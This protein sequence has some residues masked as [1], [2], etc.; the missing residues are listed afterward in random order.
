M[1]VFCQNSYHAFQIT[2]RYNLIMDLEWYDLN[3]NHVVNLIKLFRDIK[4]YDADKTEHEEKVTFFLI[5]SIFNIFDLLALKI[6]Y[7]T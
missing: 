3:L 4:V 7:I 2:S 1:E 6:F 5:L